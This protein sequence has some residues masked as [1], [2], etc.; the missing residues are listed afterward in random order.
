MTI[1]KIIQNALFF[2]GRP[3]LTFALDDEEN[4]DGEAREAIDTLLFC[5]NAVE[6][7]LARCYIPLKASES[8]VT[9]DGYIPYSKLKKRV[10]KVLSVK[11]GGE[12]AKF[13]ADRDG[14]KTC[15]GVVT[16]EYG[17]APSPKGISDAS[18][19]SDAEAGECLVAAGAASEFCLI[20]GDAAGAQAWEKRYRH[21]ID[22]ARG[23]MAST[24]EM[25]P[26]RWV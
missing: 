16:V 20:R 10:I 24:R 23:R 2:S 18:E 6:D 19:F 21:E 7:E 11:K 26:R 9:A 5:V 3:D 8:V 17:F 13:T 25:P 12:L 1:K 4:A 22:A 15:V 14:I